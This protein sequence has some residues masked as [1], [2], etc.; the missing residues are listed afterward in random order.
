[1]RADGIEHYLTSMLFNS[2]VLVALR[3]K[4]NICIFL[5]TGQIIE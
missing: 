5:Y 1:M 2:F 3:A 4:E